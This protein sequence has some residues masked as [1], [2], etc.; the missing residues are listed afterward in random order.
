MKSGIEQIQA[1]RQRQ[2][3]K[4]GFTGEHH[5]QHPEWYDKGQLIEAARTLTMPKILS[6]F[7]PINWDTEWFERLCK[8]PFQERI[9]VAAA[10][11]AS[12]LDRQNNLLKN[13]A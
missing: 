4:Y 3:D 9:V 13:E 1:E 11:L 7:V 8:K 6:V 10:L 5:A 12:E 2:I